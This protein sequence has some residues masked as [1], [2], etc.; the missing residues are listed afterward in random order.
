MAG[1]PWRPKGERT[2]ASGFMSS[3]VLGVLGKFVWRV[4]LFVVC[5]CV[6]FGV[7]FIFTFLLGGGGLQKGSQRFASHT[8]RCRAY[9]GIGCHGDF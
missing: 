1:A 5:A 8:Q 3:A 2:T 6:F 4:F 9:K 7:L